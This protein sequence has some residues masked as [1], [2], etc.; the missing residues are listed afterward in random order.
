M[1]AR[2]R[3]FSQISE[4]IFHPDFKPL[5]L[6]KYFV[7]NRPKNDHLKMFSKLQVPKMAHLV[8]FFLNSRCNEM[9]KRISIFKSVMFSGR[10]SKSTSEVLQNL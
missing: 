4:H 9:V 5:N 7:E 10:K 8:I 1:P 6:F 2:V 3:L